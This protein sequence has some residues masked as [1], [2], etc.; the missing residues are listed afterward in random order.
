[1]RCLILGGAGFLG[2]HLANR[3]LREQNNIITV[4][5]R[6]MASFSNI[7]TVHNNLR[8]VTGNFGAD[9]NFRELLENQEIVYHLVSTTVPSTS[10]INLA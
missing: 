8:M 3:L 6:E 4:F 2:S 1:M 5:D 7:K 10:N 9:Y